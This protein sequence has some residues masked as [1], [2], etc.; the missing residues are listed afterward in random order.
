MKKSYTPD[1]I[2]R[3][4]KSINE[5]LDMSVTLNIKQL[6]NTLKN[7]VGCPHSINTISL[8]VKANMIKRV[9]RNNYVINKVTLEQCRFFSKELHKF[10]SRYY[11][12]ETKEYIKKTV[13]PSTLSTNNLLDSFKDLTL[14]QIQSLCKELGIK[15]VIQ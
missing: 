1:E 5:Q 8:Y 9:S 6:T 12:Q 3:A 4:F 11:N 7:Q 15:I 10:R 14:T 2:F 13:E